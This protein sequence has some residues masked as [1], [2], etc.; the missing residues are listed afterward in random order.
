MVLIE[1]LIKTIKENKE[2]IFSKKK[3]YI[4]FNGFLNN[5]LQMVFLSST[6]LL[7]FMYFMY[8]N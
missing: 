2:F 5:F 4:S 6:F 3:M 7:F 1:V 8:I